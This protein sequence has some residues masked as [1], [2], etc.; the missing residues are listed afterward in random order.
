[1]RKF[2]IF[3][4]WRARTGGWC[5]VPFSLWAT[6][7]FWGFVIFNFCFEWPRTAFAR[8]IQASDPRQPAGHE[9]RRMA[10]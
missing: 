6:E 8:E 10:P 3:N 2:R 7:D 4:Q 9:A 5:F 1:M